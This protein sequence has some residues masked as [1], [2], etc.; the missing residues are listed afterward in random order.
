MWQD[1]TLKKFCRS[2]RS[3]I[4]HE[5]EIDMGTDSQGED[6][7]IVS[8]NSLYLNRKWSL[9]MANVEMEAG[10]TALESPYKI[11]TGSEGNLMPLYIF[12]KLFKNMGKE[13]LKKSVKGN[14]KL[15]TYN[16]MHITQLGMCAVHIKF[17][18]IKKDVYSL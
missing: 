7:E 15:K 1:G 5:V 8:I 12:C 13:Q 17:K 2:K 14:I 6:I 11:N 3:C 10:E 18:N 16:G 9:I 4:V